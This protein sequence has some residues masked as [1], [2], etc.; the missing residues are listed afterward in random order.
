VSRS[1]IFGKR[2]GSLTIMRL[3]ERMT[4]QRIPF[5]PAFV[6][7]LDAFGV[8]VGACGE[9]DVHS[10]TVLEPPVTL[11]GA[12]LWRDR[13]SVGAFSYFGARSVF[14]NAS[15]GRYCS[16]AEGLQVGMTQHPAGWLTTSPV[17]YFPDFMNFER[18]FH[19][20]EPEW[21][22]GL[23]VLDYEQRPATTIGNDV[24]VGTN[25]YLKDGITVGDGAII[26]AHSVV[27]R[28]VPPYAVVAGQPARVIRMR[29]A[30]P[31]VER[32]LA[33]RWWRFNILELTGLD[34]R[35][36]ERAVAAFEEAI[37]ADVLPLY[38]PATVNL[39]EEYG[40]FRMIQDLLARSAA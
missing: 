11:F 7:H 34:V 25:V 4:L 21:R 6:V 40:R 14:A 18:H 23:D 17:P 35:D 24:W 32:L 30:E 2:D 27:T 38:E 29:F 26:G 1:I 3:D 10:D 33:I 31:L 9:F 12:D 20:C 37:A 16:F 13:V 36:P 15:A 5:T 39:V 19:E 22:R 8:S 28:D